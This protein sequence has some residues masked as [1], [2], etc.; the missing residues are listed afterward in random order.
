MNKYI[1]ILILFDFFR[2]LL[3]SYSIEN[4]LNS[5][6][7]TFRLQRAQPLMATTTRSTSLYVPPPQFDNKSDASFP[8]RST[9]LYVPPP[10]FDN[11]SDVSFHTR[12]SEQSTEY[13]PV[14]R[15]LSPDDVQKMKYKIELGL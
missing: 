15:T 8:T 9:S 7:Q 6:I 5:F 4:D 13:P 14:L 3:N 1:F 10:Q 11:K 12:S 2:L